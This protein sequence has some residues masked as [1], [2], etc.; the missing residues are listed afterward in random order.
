MKFR[1]R[2]ENIHFEEFKK[3]SKK[4]LICSMDLERQLGIFVGC[5]CWGRQPETTELQSCIHNSVPL[6]FNKPSL[7]AYCI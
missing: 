7:S 3:C 4:D 1:S 6:L 2:R 5:R